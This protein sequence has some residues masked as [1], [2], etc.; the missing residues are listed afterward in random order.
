M[1]KPLDGA[2]L[3]VVRAQEH[4][5]SLKAE[6][7]MYLGSDPYEFPIEQQG[8][9][10]TTK[11]VTGEPPIRLSTIVGDCVGNARAALDY[12]VWQLAVKYLSDPPLGVEEDT[13]LS[14][15][16]YRDPTDLGYVNKINRFTNRK[17][18][19]LAIAE[20][21]ATQ[22]HNAGY[23]PLWWL[24]ELVNRDKHRLPLLTRVHAHFTDIEIVKRI[25]GVGT[26]L[27]SAT[28]AT[29]LSWHDASFPAEGPRSG[30]KMEVYGQATGFVALQDVSMPREP[31]DRTLEQIVECVATV[32]ER[33]DRFF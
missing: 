30:D 6:I 24:H 18:P 2:R 19:A 9:R 23:E 12:I 32:V 27:A 11:V 31:V 7:R 17:I 1:N 20:I 25:G 4:L 13:W 21:N 16:I 3:K 29:S 28:G 33:F 15:P 5:D 10:W 14:F 22:P 8:N 26:S